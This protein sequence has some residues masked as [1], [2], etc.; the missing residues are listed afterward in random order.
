M[1]KT[2][3]ITSRPS[4]TRYLRDL[5][6]HKQL[7]PQIAY[8][9]LVVRYKQSILGVLWALLDPIFTL[10]IFIFVF[11]VLLNF[12]SDNTAVPYPL[13]IIS[14]LVGWQLFS[15]NLSAVGDSLLA[16]EHILKKIYFPRIILAIGASLT[17]LVD[18]LIVLLFF[19]IILIIYRIDLSARMLWIVPLIAHAFLLGFGPGLIISSLNIRFR[20]FKHIV[21]LILRL[22]FYLSPVPY[23]IELIV[24]QARFPE[25]VVNIYFINPLI[26]VINAFRWAL[27]DTE[28][29]APALIYSI[30]FMCICLV[31]GIFIFFKRESI[32]ADEI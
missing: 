6:Y 10:L 28:L 16:G 19:I 23:T 26:G 24:N 5:F 30:C 4:F 11:G 27:L 9:N 32:I 7:I 17:I 21:P 18:F 2:S 25:W 15:L 31:C 1:G 3:L 29:H 22:G 12:R 8:R 14:G 20:D 13:I